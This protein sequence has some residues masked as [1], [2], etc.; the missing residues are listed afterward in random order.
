MQRLYIAILI[1]ALVL[2]P[3][4]LGFDSPGHLVPRFPAPL[5]SGGQCCGEVLNLEATVHSVIEQT[6]SY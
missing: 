1:M 5:Q 6:S 2:S 3:T 4:V